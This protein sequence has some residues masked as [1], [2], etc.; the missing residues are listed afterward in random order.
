MSNQVQFTTFT[1]FLEEKSKPKPKK[2][3][4]SEDLI[5]NILPC[6]MNKKKTFEDSCC[7][8]SEEATIFDLN[9][10][11][12]ESSLDSLDFVD[13]KKKIEINWAPP[14]RIQRTQFS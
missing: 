14:P 12:Y 4:I 7:V 5:F 11:I 9:L 13:K 6:L 3:V 8:R 10:E 1:A 2:T